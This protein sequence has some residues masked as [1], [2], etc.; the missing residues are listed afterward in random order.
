MSSLFGTEESKIVVRRLFLKTS[1]INKLREQKFRGFLLRRSA[2]RLYSAWLPTS[3]WGTHK[4]RL[5][6]NNPCLDAD[7]IPTAFDTTGRYSLTQIAAT[8][9][10]NL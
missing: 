6:H 1:I 7:H 3:R 9:A 4:H 10:L 2:I 5:P 8:V